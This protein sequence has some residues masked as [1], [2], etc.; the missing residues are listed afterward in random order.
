MTQMLGLP[1]PVLQIGNDKPKT[2]PW[3]EYGND[4][5][6]CDLHRIMGQL[7][8]NMAC[9]HGVD[10]VGGQRRGN[11]AFAMAVTLHP[12]GADAGDKGS[13]KGERNRT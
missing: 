6:R 4:N 11:Q 1:R 9:K 7:L 10:G 13:R 3:F 12:A 8:E 2:A 5:S